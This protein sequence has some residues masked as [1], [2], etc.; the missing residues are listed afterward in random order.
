MLWSTNA[1]ARCLALPDRPEFV[2]I[3]HAHMHSVVPAERGHPGA[4]GLARDAEEY[5]RKRL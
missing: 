3:L 5:A 4:A 1:L 2:A